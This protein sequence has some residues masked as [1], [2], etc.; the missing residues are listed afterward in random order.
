MAARA[1]RTCC[2]LDGRT[3]PGEELDVEASRPLLR[4]RVAALFTA[5]R[6]GGRRR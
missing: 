5:G 6:P 1:A 3:R 2:L 4:C